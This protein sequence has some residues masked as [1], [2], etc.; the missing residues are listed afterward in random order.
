MQQNIY[1]VVVVIVFGILHFECSNVHAECNQFF[2]GDPWPKLKRG[3]RIDVVK[4]C[5]TQLHKY[6]NSY[7]EGK[8]VFATL[9]STRDRIPLYTANVV[10]INNAKGF[11]RPDNYFWDR[12]A[13]ALC[14]VNI[15]PQHPINSRIGS[16]N[17]F[18]NCGQ[19]QA[20]DSDYKYNGL[21]LDRGHISPNSI[22]SR[23]RE[24][25]EGTFTLTNAAPQFASFNRYWWRVVECITEKS[26]LNLVPNQDV[27]IMTGTFGVKIDFKGHAILMNNRVTV[28]GAFWKAVCY[29]GNLYHA[30]WGYAII[31]E[32]SSANHPLEFDQYMTLKDFSK[33]FTNKPFGASCLNAGMG[34]FSGVWNAIKKECSKPSFHY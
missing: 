23:D 25:Q 21:G 11:K 12:V 13:T 32:N 4:L 33:Y 3:V 9:Y 6:K 34:P 28:P 27:Y 5:Q 30:P 31:R 1:K 22:N 8:V 14:D 29:P 20:L 16:A 17:G 10:N 7:W 19:Y 24:K 15:L 2:N 26:I 18:E